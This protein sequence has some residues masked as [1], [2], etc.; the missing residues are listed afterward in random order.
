MLKNLFVWVLVATIF[1]KRSFTMKNIKSRKIDTSILLLAVFIMSIPLFMSSY[2][3]IVD[4]LMEATRSII[5][6]LFNVYK[7]YINFM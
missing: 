3:L 4:A 1:Y 6:S 2:V 5:L 7:N